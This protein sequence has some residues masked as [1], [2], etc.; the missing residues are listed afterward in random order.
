MGFK[1]E[2]LYVKIRKIIVCVLVHILI[3]P[4]VFALLSSVPKSTN[5]LTSSELREIRTCTRP[6]YGP[7]RSLDMYAV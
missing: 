7:E 3:S 6:S 1:S 5:L 2:K 4:T